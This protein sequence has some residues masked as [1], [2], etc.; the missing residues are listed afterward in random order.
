MGIFTGGFWLAT[1][2]RAAKSAAQAVLGLWAVGDGMFNLL[3]MDWQI[4]LG[5]A[6]TGIAFS[7]LTS[8]VA[9]PYGPD[10]SDP[11]LV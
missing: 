2:E 4:A 6:V 1:A 11:S 8:I 3:E 7:V 9:A 5:A 10:S